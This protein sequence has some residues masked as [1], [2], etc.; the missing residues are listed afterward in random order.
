VDL[1]PARRSSIALRFPGK[2]GK[3]HFQMNIGS[4]HFDEVKT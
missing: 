3:L 4:V 1:A 2:F